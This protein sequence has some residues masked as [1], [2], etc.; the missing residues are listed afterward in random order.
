M[1]NVLLRERERERDREREQEG[2]MLKQLNLV[3]S[4]MFPQ[5]AVFLSLVLAQINSV[6]YS[7]LHT[8]THRKPVFFND[9]ARSKNRC[10]TRWQSCT[11]EVCV[12]KSKAPTVPLLVPEFNMSSVCVSL[13]ICCFTIA[14]VTTMILTA[15]SQNNIHNL[16]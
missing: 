2:E 13:S 4:H 15:I 7:S 8:H 16:N 6:P 14:S 5:H 10:C 3:H 11:I 9:P 1:M 12:K